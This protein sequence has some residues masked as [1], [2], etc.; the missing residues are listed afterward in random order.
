M[1]SYSTL[2]ELNYLHRLLLQWHEEAMFLNCLFNL[3]ITLGI[4][5]DSYKNVLLIHFYRS[6]SRSL[7]HACLF[8]KNPLVPSEARC[9]TVPHRRQRQSIRPSFGKR[10]KI[11][12]P[13]TATTAVIS[14]VM[15]T[16]CLVFVKSTH[17]SPLWKIA[18]ILQLHLDS[19]ISSSPQPRE[20]LMSYILQR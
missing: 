1:V 17:F 6:D 3:Q 20:H 16:I 9:K 14:T 4:S 8:L 18:Q 5:L 7:Q 10:K 11:T 12:M 19:S 13:P 2:Q 15:V